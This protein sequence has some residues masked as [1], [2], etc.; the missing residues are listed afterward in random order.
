MLDCNSARAK[1]YV[2]RYQW[3]GTLPRPVVTTAWR[4][5]IARPGETARV[6]ARLPRGRWDVS[7]QY[8][9]RTPLTVRGP[10][11]SK[12]LAPNLGPVTSFWPAGT[13]TSDGRQV[14]LSL[15]SDRRNWFGRLL[16]APTPERAPLAP[17]KRPLHVI[18]F[19]RHGA[20]PQRIRS[21]R[22]CG[23]YVDW[24]APAGSSMRGR[25]ADER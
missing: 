12:R 14:T 25:S 2:T 15:T 23:R 11:L 18:A 6:T 10:G 3:A 1:R 21:R 20:T 19:T 16:G 8:V 4:G 22:A 24:L 9:S 13:L 17:G 5:S 7:L